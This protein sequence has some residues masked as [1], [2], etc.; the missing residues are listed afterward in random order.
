M[1]GMGLLEAGWTKRYLKDASAVDKF[2]AV[3]LEA[4]LLDEAMNPA[5]HHPNAPKD[6]S[7]SE[8]VAIVGNFY[9]YRQAMVS[10][11]ASKE[12]PL[13]LFGALPPRWSVPE[14]VE[15]YRNEFVVRERKSSVFRS[16]LAVL[17][18]T[19]LA[20]GDTL[21]CRAFEACGAGA[22]HLLEP[23]KAVSRCFEPGVEVLTY[24]SIDDL[25][26]ITSRASADPAWAAKIRD[27]GSARAHAHHKYEDRLRIIF[28]DLERALPA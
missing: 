10:A 4:A 22:L 1:V 2:R 24:T 14:V 15:G 18:S 3:G 21:N 27:A 26:E 19:S 23:K 12:V 16:A 9:G 20:E 7:V 25:V 28:Q 5:W 11:L 8:H 13:A 6:N 17:N